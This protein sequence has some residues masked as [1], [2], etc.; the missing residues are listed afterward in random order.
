[1]GSSL[2]GI[3]VEKSVLKSKVFRS[4]NNTSMVV[5]FDFLMKRKMGP[6]VGKQGRSGVWQILNNGEIEYTYSEAENNKGISRQSFANALTELV[7]KGFIDI[8]HA[9]QGGTKGDKSLYAISERWKY[10]ETAKFIKKT[11]AKD[12]RQGRGFAVVHQRERE[13]QK[14]KVKKPIKRR[15]LI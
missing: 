5:Y 6:P 8:T 11:R 12:T 2:K 10:F 13:K 3:F 7:E 9:G 1:M 14:K 4:L 15:Q